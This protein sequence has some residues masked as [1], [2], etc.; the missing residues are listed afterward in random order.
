MG[1]WKL[2]RWF[3]SWSKKDYSDM[4]FLVQRICTQNTGTERT[5]TIRKK[6]KSQYNF[7]SVRYCSYDMQLIE[8]LIRTTCFNYGTGHFFNIMQKKK[9]DAR[10]HP[11]VR[12][13]ITLFQVLKI[14]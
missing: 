13:T 6:T 9:K 5:R 8:Q 4:V 14:I 3:S 1:F 7:S 10:R 12:N 2:E 11:F